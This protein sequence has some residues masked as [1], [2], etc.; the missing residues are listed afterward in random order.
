LS[1]RKEFFVRS[2]RRSFL[3]R[4]ASSLAAVAIGV[5]PTAHAASA[6][7][8]ETH[9]SSCNRTPNIEQSLQVCSTIEDGV[10]YYQMDTVDGTH[11]EL[12][13]SRE[14]VDLQQS[15]P[16][17]VRLAFFKTPDRLGKEVGSSSGIEKRVYEDALLTIDEVQDGTY[18]PS[19]VIAPRINMN[20]E[21]LLQTCPARICSGG[22]QS[23][24]D[25][26]N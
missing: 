20:V 1:A 14:G 12:M 7:Y 17:I 4:Y 9:G 15:G 11:V 10:V 2:L 5:G 3:I 21:P 23:H 22:I 6:T 26:S 19:W 16:D 24:S 18:P 25:G 8:A 13:V